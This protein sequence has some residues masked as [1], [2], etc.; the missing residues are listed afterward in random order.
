MTREDAREVIKILAT[1]DGGCSCCV[2]NLLYAFD[3]AFPGFR[4]FMEI[5]HE[6]TIFD[7]EEDFYYP[8]EEIKK[9]SRGW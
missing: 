2:N 8:S 4:E 6:M 5:K 7:R 9:E 1:A 3:K